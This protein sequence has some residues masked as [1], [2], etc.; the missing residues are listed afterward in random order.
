MHIK[1][2]G[3]PTPNVKEGVNEKKD[4]KIVTQETHFSNG[5]LQMDM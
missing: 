4:K 5:N 1:K 3:Y 2:C